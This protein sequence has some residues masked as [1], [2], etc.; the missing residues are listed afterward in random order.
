MTEIFWPAEYT[1]VIV[2]A[3]QHPKPYAVKTVDHTFFRDFFLRSRSAS[4]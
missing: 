2:S 3:R 1:Q 4:A